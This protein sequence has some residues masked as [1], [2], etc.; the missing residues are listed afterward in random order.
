MSS[1]AMGGLLVLGAALLD[2]LIGDPRWM[3]H[4][5]VVMGWSIRQLRHVGSSHG[6][7]TIR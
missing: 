3:L 7:E 5:V 1:E 2:Q 4:P 6:Q